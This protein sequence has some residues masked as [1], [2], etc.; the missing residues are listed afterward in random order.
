[1]LTNNRIVWFLLTIIVLIGLEFR[2]QAVMYTEVNQPI[3]ADAKDYIAYAHNISQFQTYSRS[4][5]SQKPDA[6]RSPG[7]P[8]FLTVFLD[9]HI[10]N[11]SL[12]HVLLAQVVLSTLTILLVYSL[13]ATLLG[14]SFALLVA[15]LTA[16][17]P[18]LIT[19][20]VYYLSEP[21]FCF[22]LVSFLWLLS[23]KHH[24]FIL[25]CLGVIL[26]AA[27]L[28]RPWLQY[29]IFLLIPLLVFSHFPRKVSIYIGIAFLAIMSLWITRNIVTMGAASNSKLIAGSLH[30]G[31]YPNFMYDKKPESYGFPY[32]FDPRSSEISASLPSVL[33][34]IKRRFQEHPLEHLQWYLFGKPLTLLSWNIIQGMGDVFIYPVTRTPYDELT[35]FK[36]SHD[37][38]KFIHIP[39]VILAIIGSLIAWRSQEDLKLSQK[40]L[41]VVR[42]ISLLLG[43]FILLHMV[44][45]PFPRYTVPM[46]P[47]IYGMAIFGGVQLFL[48]VKAKYA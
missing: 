43:Y 4:F 14:A 38:M 1:M 28:T 39:L 18:H 3:R 29:F 9:K 31:M 40:S 27:S 5:S 2:L 11:N 33:T 23:K 13:F 37:L 12:Y 7:Y 21:L 19:M 30:H 42:S 36:I 24:P 25:L 22:L 15:L 20:N 44:V 48:G 26:A 41:L 34:E 45:A 47:I 16:L 6:V 17:S 46:L 35:H 8:I 10:S 32:R